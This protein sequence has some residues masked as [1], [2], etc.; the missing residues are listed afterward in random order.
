MAKYRA[1]Y[2]HSK[3]A[4][5]IEAPTMKHLYD[6]ARSD[7]RFAMKHINYQGWAV[8]YESVVF[9][10][11]SESLQAWMILGVMYLNIHATPL[12]RHTSI[13]LG[14]GKGWMVLHNQF[15]EV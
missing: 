12:F 8:P 14:V 5:E 1:E 3:V 6:I 7:F 9:Y 11:W 10:K 2:E 15:E 13:N 4:I